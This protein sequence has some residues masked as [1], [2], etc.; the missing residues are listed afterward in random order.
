MNIK[1]NEY[2]P[3]NKCSKNT[4]PDL[5]E[6]K[7]SCNAFACFADWDTKEGLPVSHKWRGLA[8]EGGEGVSLPVGVI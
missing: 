7:R 2:R 5:K 8:L 3:S 4:K 6:T 1:A